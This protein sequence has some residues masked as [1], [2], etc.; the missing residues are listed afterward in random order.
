MTVDLSNLSAEKRVF[1][2]AQPG[3]L[4]SLE[5]QIGKQAVKV[6]NRKEREN[7][8]KSKLQRELELI[9]SKVEKIK[10]KAEKLRRKYDPHLMRIQR[11]FISQHPVDRGT[12][13]LVCPVCRR[14]DEECGHNKMNGKPWCHQ[15]KTQLI[16]KNKLEKWR[17]MVNVKAVRSSLKDEFKRKGLD[18]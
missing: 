10:D 11:A 2:K 7:R 17:K 13:S 18:F 3:L 12:K 5:E 15:C 8:G 4:R 16:P 1:L 14:S 9:D 6:Q